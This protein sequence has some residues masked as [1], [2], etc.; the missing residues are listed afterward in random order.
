MTTSQQNTD[1]TWAPASPLPLRDLVDY[2][3]TGHGPY[4][5]VAFRGTEHLA[6][7]TARTRLGLTIAL[8]RARRNSA[9]KAVR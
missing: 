7:G 5:W 4:R 9:S 2:E 1:G 8:L 3:V 6:C